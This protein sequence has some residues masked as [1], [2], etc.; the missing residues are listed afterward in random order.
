MN[1]LE[2]EKIGIHKGI[3]IGGFEYHNIISHNGDIRILFSLEKIQY[4]YL[5]ND[6]AMSICDFM[7]N[8]V[9]SN[10][11]YKDTAHSLLEGYEF[12]LEKFDD[13][14][15]EL[16]HNLILFNLILFF[17]KHEIKTEYLSIFENIYLDPN[18]LK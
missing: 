11:S 9:E 12:E 17:I 10:L 8:S 2:N 13:L 6:L 16:L 5:I 3:I 15:K 7:L 1:Q 18:F 14:H 4:S